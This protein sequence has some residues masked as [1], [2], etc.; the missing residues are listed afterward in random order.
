MDFRVLFCR[1]LF[2]DCAPLDFY[3]IF[4]SRLSMGPK[5]IPVLK[6][7]NQFPSV[8]SV[9]HRSRGRAYRSLTISFRGLPSIL[10]RF[11]NGK[12]PRRHDATQFS[13]K[14]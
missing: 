7:P 12:M 6:G 9:L 13:A 10:L 14:L 4:D 2:H 11:I 3:V 8:K 1:G 5:E